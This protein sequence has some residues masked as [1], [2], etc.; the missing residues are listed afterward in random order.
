[1]LVIC[2]FKIY[3]TDAE[4]IHETGFVCYH[5]PMILFLYPALERSSGNSISESGIPPRMF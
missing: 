5:F 1:M 2:H 3:L 4:V